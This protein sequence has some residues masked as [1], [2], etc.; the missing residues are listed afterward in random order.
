VI[1]N[2]LGVSQ[3]PGRFRA[4]PQLILLELAQATESTLPCD[5]VRRYVT[6]L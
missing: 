3:L 1:S 5:D 4:K 6:R 2:G